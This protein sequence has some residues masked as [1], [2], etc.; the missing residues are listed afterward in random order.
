MPDVRHFQPLC[1]ALQAKDDI[2]PQDSATA[3]CG[4][5]GGEFQV[6]RRW[7]KHCSNRCRV[8]VQRKG[9]LVEGYYGA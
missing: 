6:M 4:G 9:Q 8:R 3:L 1:A 7:Q 5:C 2:P